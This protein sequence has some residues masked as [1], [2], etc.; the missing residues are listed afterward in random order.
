MLPE[1]NIKSARRTNKYVRIFSYLVLSI[2]I[3]LGVFVLIG[4][5]RMAFPSLQIPL[6]VV[7]V[8]Y[9]AVRLFMQ[10]LKYREEDKSELEEKK[11]IDKKI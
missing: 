9:G 4:V 10:I 7:I 11:L 3:L 6:G 2:V 8:G 5:F 1:G